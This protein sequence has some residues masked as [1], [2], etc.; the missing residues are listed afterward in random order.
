MVRIP[1]FT[2]CR[3]PIFAVRQNGPHSGDECSCTIYIYIPQFNRISPVWAFVY[4]SEIALLIRFRQFVTHA[5]VITHNVSA[6][7]IW[8]IT[9]LLFNS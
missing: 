4:H 3:V 8:T 5:S 1:D 6:Y 7:Y 2:V 9:A